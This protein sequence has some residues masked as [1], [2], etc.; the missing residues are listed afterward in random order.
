MFN[1]SMIICKKSP[2]LLNM[3]PPLYLIS[4]KAP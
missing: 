4:N 2:F 1:F 3:K